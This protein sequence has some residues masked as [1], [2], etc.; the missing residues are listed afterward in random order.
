M[1]KIKLHGVGIGGKEVY[2]SKVNPNH[3]FYYKV[4]VLI[5]KLSNKKF[6]ETYVW[7][8]HKNELEKEEKYCKLHP[9]RPADYKSRQKVL[10]EKDISKILKVNHCLD[11]YP[12]VNEDFRI[13]MVEEISKEEAIKFN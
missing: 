12:E 5:S 4:T 10:L 13:L 1:S 8:V 9:I 11:Y 6:A 2:S 7:A 3:Y